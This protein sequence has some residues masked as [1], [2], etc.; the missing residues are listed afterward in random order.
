[1]Q[2]G[3]FFGTFNPIH[4]GHVIIGN[5]I[6]ENTTMQ[7]VWFVVTP[8]NP[9]KQKATL[10]DDY[11]RLEMVHRALAPYDKLRPSDIEFH[12]PQPS[13][14]VNTLQKL[15]EKYPQHSF[16]L[17]IGEDNLHTLH[18]WKNYQHLLAHYPIYVYPRIGSKKGIPEVLNHHHIHLTQTPMVD[19][20]ATFIR[21]QVEAGKNTRALMPAEAWQYMDE[22][23]FYKS[24]YVR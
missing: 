13:Y 2:I 12:L 8:H 11:Q 4:V 19:I 18:K 3:L 22:M 7:Q 15:E 9:L 17:I 20:S 10:L 21:K 16:A 5:Y 14:T 1:M 6:A 24:T 23:N